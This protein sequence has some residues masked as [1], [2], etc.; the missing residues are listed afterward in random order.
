MASPSSSAVRLAPVLGHVANPGARPTLLIGSA[1]AAREMNAGARPRL[2]R[3]QHGPSEA[4]VEDLAQAVLAMGVLTHEG[5]AG[6]DKLHSSW[7]TK[8]GH[9]LGACPQPWLGAPLCGAP[10]AHKCAAGSGAAQESRATGALI[11]MA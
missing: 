7:L 6:G 10:H 9:G 2:A 4:R 3:A 1:V 5:A 11:P 8:I